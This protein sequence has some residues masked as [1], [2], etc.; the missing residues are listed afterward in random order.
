MGKHIGGLIFVLL[1]CGCADEGGT[2]NINIDN[3]RECVFG[4]TTSSC[5]D[6]SGDFT[7]EGESNDLECFENEVGEASQICGDAN[8]IDA[9]ISSA[10]SNPGLVDFLIRGYRGADP[11]SDSVELFN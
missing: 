9:V 7:P 5:V 2:T 1:F 3:S 8:D 6:L 4:T 11:R 10:E